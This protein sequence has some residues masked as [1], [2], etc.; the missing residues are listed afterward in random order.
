MAFLC[1]VCYLVVFPDKRAFFVAQIDG[2]FMALSVLDEGK[3]GAAAGAGA[4][5]PA[6]SAA[7]AA[8]TSAGTGGGAGAAAPAG[9]A[10]GGD[11]DGLDAQYNTEH[12]LLFDTVRRIFH[13]LAP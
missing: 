6:S 11:A 12:K 5:S 13:A 9:A 1:P 10:A 2:P 4:A 3:A 7:A 8:A